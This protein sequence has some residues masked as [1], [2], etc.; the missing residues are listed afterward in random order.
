MLAAASISGRTEM[1]YQSSAIADIMIPLQYFDAIQLAML[2]Y[3]SKLTALPLYNSS[4]FRQMCQ[5]NWYPAEYAL[6]YIC[7]WGYIH[8]RYAF[9]AVDCAPFRTC[10]AITV[11]P[12]SR[13]PVR[14][15]G[16]SLDTSV[17]RGCGWQRCACSYKNNRE[18]AGTTARCQG[19]RQQIY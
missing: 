5:R 18:R 16:V 1:R 8:L 10:A 19:K 2:I 4:K 3:A 12:I 9:E 17:L 15:P 11:D 13:M 7:T 14:S 6:D